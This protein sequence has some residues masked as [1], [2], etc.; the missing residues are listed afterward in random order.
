MFLSPLL[1]DKRS[2]NK[3][4]N[5][6]FQLRSEK[7]FLPTQRQS[8]LILFPNFSR[9]LDRKKMSDVLHGTFRDFWKQKKQTFK[10]HYHWTFF[11][12]SADGWK[13]D[14]EKDDLYEIGF[15]TPIYTL[16][17]CTNCNPQ[18]IRT[19]KLLIRADYCLISLSI[20]HKS[21]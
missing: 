5:W 14:D 12:R 2:L 4:V 10:Q 20:E 15:Q 3:F 17:T 13:D 18:Y 11:Q 19:C 6:I 9:R 21:T 16:I 1:G 8:Y 7:C